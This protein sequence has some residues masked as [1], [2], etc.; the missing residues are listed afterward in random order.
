[1]FWG[2]GLRSYCLMH[3]K[4]IRR[5]KYDILLTLCSFDLEGGRRVLPYG[6]FVFFPSLFVSV[7]SALTSCSSEV[8]TTWKHWQE[9][10]LYREE[11]WYQKSCH[12]P[13]NASYPKY[14]LS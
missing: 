8:V 5:L 10:T 12:Q 14:F 3:Q 13:V 11:I 7:R 6:S 2:R 4:G 1:M 9:M